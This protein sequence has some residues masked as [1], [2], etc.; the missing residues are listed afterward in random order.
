MVA[1]VR[2]F[3]ES[4]Q[5]VRPHPTEVDC[6]HRVVRD[7][8]HLLLHLSTL[9]SDQRQSGPKSSQS[10]QLDEERAGEL[11]SIIQ[12]AFPALRPR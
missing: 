6:E 7:G 3:R 5:G 12:S 2:L 11:L 10:M 1:R 8:D 4:Q 9:G